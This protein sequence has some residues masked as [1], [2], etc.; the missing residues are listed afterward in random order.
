MSQI[1]FVDPA[2]IEPNVKKVSKEVLN[3]YFRRQCTIFRH[4]HFGSFMKRSWKNNE[5]L[6]QLFLTRR[7]REM[8]IDTT[9]YF[10]IW[11]SMRRHFSMWHIC[12]IMLFP[13][14]LF[15]ILALQID[16]HIILEPI[17]YGVQDTVLVIFPQFEVQASAYKTLGIVC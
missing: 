17:K 5:I 4:K 14:T 13:T 10:V 15:G 12:A 1:T 11:K 8:N 16:C 2:R 6:K 9:I 7:N 3:R